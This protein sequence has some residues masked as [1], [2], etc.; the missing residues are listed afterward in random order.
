MPP[1]AEEVSSLRIVVRP[2]MN[3]NVAE[4]LADDIERAC[5][6]LEEHGGNATPPKL[7]PAHHASPAKC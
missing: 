7:H 6:F 2:H 4:L 1:N 5:D 3:R